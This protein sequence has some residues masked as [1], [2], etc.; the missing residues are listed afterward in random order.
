MLSSS[1]LAVVFL[2]VPHARPLQACPQLASAPHSQWKIVVHNGVSWLMTPCGER[3]LS[4][5]VNALDGGYPSRRFD[6]RLA[7]HWGTFYPDVDTWGAVTR[8]RLMDWGFNTVGAWSL[9]PSKLV[10]PFIPNLELGRTSRFH[11]FDPFR[12]TM[13]EDMRA[14]AR[15]LVAPYKGN[16]YR[17]GYFADNEIGWWYSALFIYY[18]QQPA[19]NYT[20]QK[21]LALLR[22]QYDNDWARFVHD[23]VPPTGVASFPDLLQSTAKTHLRAGG[24]GIQ[25]IRR[26]TSIVAEHYYRL[27][28]RTIRDVDPEALIF[29]DRLQIYYDPDAVRP[30]QPYIDVVA[31]NYDVDG[32]DGSIARYYFDGL[33]QLTGN[34]PVIVSE[35]FFAA[36]ENRTGNLNNG[37]LMTVQTQAERTQGAIAAA[38][39]FVKIPQL[40]GL[41]WFQYYDH[42]FGGRT[43][44]EDYNFG[45][46]DIHDRPYEALT[47]A[48]RHLNPRLAA[49]HQEAGHGTSTLPL[50]I[51][52]EI[53]EVAIDL[54]DRSLREWPKERALVPGLTAPSP[55]VVF[56]DVY[57]AWDHTGVYV[58]TISMDYYDPEL[59]AYGDTFPL[60]EAFRLEWGIDAG[61]GPQ[62]FALYIVPP[63]EVPQAGPVLARAHLCHV[64]H[65][66]CESVPVASASYFGSSPRLVA[67]VALPWR[68]LGVD[69]PP[70]AR[71][72]RVELTATSS[73]RAR[74]MSWS[75]LPPAVGMQDTTA[76]HVVRLGSR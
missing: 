9:G 45:L 57:L 49:L 8:Q 16:P 18:L 58:A 54:H 76:W 3:F 29:T 15:R 34:K 4:I 75:G 44:G 22:A 50:D 17:I 26:W 1:L 46:V 10:L 25:V 70:Q 41:H 21:L 42:P 51:P 2:A 24:T 33:R 60:E 71:H 40:I 53:P 19:T 38:Q 20:K 48:F 55:E 52:W 68:A 35:W 11:W 13:E 14:T 66:H 27:L 72:L 63:K 74:W 69:G 65:G 39:A 61:A 32:Q 23:F 56:G 28:H 31:T 47:E 62:R 43:D 67:E 37:H 12:P 7:Y 5:G 73:H 30:M 59:L 6:G 36:H 64:I